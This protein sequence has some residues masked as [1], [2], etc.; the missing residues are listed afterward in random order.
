[1]NNEDERSIK[2]WDYKD[3]AIP[4]DKLKPFSFKEEPSY[5]ITFF[6]GGNPQDTVGELDFNSGKLD[7]KGDVTEAG[8]LFV[9]FVLKTFNAKVQE[10]LAQ[11]TTEVR[12]ELGYFEDDGK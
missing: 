11:R 4:A 2:D 9:D 6:R 1:M 12:E 5:T 3:I 7:F 10:M 8:G